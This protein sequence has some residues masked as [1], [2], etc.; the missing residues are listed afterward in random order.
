MFV[1]VTT[2]NKENTKDLKLISWR[3]IASISKSSKTLYRSVITFMNSDRPLDVFE[4]EEEILNKIQNSKL[5]NGEK[6]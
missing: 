1:K 6:L 4:S 5:N 3:N 2:L